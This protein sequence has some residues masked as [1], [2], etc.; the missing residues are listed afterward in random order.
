LSTY[1]FAIIVPA[2]AAGRSL[3]GHGSRRPVDLFDFRDSQAII[4]GYALGL[5]MCA[6]PAHD[7]RH[8]HAPPGHARL[9][10]KPVHYVLVR[11]VT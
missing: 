11:R 7:V 10:D 6:N 1:H 9:D 5:L 8:S 3:P 2:I 4:P